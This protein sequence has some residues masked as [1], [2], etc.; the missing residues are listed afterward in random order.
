M[1]SMTEAMLTQQHAAVFEQQR[2]FLAEFEQH[3][4]Y[5]QSTMSRHHHS[6]FHLLQFVGKG[7]QGIF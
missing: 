3:I 1:K 7:G 6:P 4:N 5:Q 2:S